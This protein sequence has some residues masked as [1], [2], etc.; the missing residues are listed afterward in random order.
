MMSSP[1]LDVKAASFKASSFVWLLLV[2]LL[3]FFAAIR[4]EM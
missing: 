3:F 1:V 2:F 4:L